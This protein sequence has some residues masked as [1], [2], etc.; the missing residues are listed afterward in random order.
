MMRFINPSDL[1]VYEASDNDGRDGGWYAQHYNWRHH[2]ATPNEAR[3]R[4]SD[5][6]AKIPALKPGRQSEIKTT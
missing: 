4:L 3:K 5:N 2:G 1:A 6:L